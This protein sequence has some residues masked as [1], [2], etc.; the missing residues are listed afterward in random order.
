MRTLL[1]AVLALSTTPAFA[2]DPCAELTP[3]AADYLNANPGWAVIR[4]ADL[5]ADDRVLWAR[6][7]R[8]ECP[9]FALADLDGSGR[10]FAVLGL[11]SRRADDDSERVV[12]VRQVL[13]GLEVRVLIPDERAYSPLVLFR[14]PPGKAREWDSGTEIAIAHDSVGVA[15]REA[16]SRQYYWSKG[17]FVCVQ[18]SD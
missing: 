5:Q 4:P 1:L 18:T 15:W 10:A 13:G 17:E 16:S 8:R 11:I 9:G 6:Q 12:L 2:A 7:H 14:L 3:A